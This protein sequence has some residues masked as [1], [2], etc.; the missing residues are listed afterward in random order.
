MF[1]LTNST[2]TQPLDILVGIFI[3]LCFLNI[4][5]FLSYKIKIHEN[6]KLN[7]SII[8][9][10]LTFS[11]AQFFFFAEW[12]GDP[13]RIPFRRKFIKSRMGPIYTFSVF[14]MLQCSR[15]AQFLSYY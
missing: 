10:I 12:Q 15:R 2:F 8:Y 14:K 9:L 11:L 3:C 13:S 1:T 7:F 6:N 5:T 4:T